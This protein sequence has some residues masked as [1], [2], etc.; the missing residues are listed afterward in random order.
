MIKLEIKF[1]DVTFEV[2]GYFYK[3]S[4]PSDPL[5]PPDPSCFE[6]ERIYLHDQEVTEMLSSWVLDGI[7]Q[8]VNEVYQ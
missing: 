7:Q 2:Q 4:Y 8:K 5:E 1:N 3:G 6:I